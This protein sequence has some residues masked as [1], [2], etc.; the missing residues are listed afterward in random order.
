MNTRKLTAILVLALAT[1]V[2]AGV[3]VSQLTR[4]TVIQSNSRFLTSTQDAVTGRWFSR[5]I[6]ADDLGTNLSQ[7]LGTN[8]G[9]SIS[10]LEDYSTNRNLLPSIFTNTVYVNARGANQAANG[11][12][13][14]NALATAPAFCRIVVGPGDYFVAEVAVP[15]PAFAV[16]NRWIEFQPGANW[17]AG[18]TNSNPFF[19]FDDG[20]GKV[21][22]VWV[23]GRGNFWQTNIAGA[24]GNL[25]Y[26]ENGSTVHFEHQSLYLTNADSALSMGGVGNNTITWR[27]HGRASTWSYDNAYFHAEAT[28]R[29][30]AFFNE[31]ETVGDLIE[32]GGDAPAWGDV[33]I[34]YNHAFMRQATASQASLMQIGGRAIVENGTLYSER[35]NASF[36]STSAVTNGQFIGGTVYLRP[37]A[38]AGFLRDNSAGTGTPFNGVTALWIKNVTIYTFLIPVLGPDSQ[39]KSVDIWCS[40]ERTKAWLSWM[41]DAKL[42]EKASASCNTP[43][44]RNLALG[45]KHRVD[46]TPALVFSDNSRVGGALPLEEIEKNLVASSKP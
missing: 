23:T 25:L 6:E 5:Y 33:V 20:G 30:D 17:R 7:W 45:R 43:I 22:N 24:S 4:T 15:S 21:T 39:A 2:V 3:K 32:T 29:L 34:R 16:D 12:L 28:N 41:L 11:L 1:L 10:G 36:Y 27:T 26:L 9:G 44:E 13:L 18:S 46:G 14:T 37:N 38:T 8:G 31:I 42:P 35:T 19:M 40:K